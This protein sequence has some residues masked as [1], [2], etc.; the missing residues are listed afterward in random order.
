MN[1]LFSNQ[2]ATAKKSDIFTIINTCSTDDFHLK[3]ELQGVGYKRIFS[4]CFGIDRNGEFGE[5]VLINEYL[6]KFI[7][8]E[9]ERSITIPVQA[10]YTLTDLANA[11]NFALIGEGFQENKTIQDEAIILKVR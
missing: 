9:L 10:F 11:L 4:E 1:I 3:A 2:S 8:D 7:D 6:N 5:I